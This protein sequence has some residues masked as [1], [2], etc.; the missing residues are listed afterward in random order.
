MFHNQ[1]KNREEAG[2]KLAERLLEW[3]E[4]NPLVLAIPRGGVAV[5]YEIAKALKAP[6]DII[7]PRKIGAP[8]NPELA[9]GAVTEDGTLVLNDDLVVAFRVSG[10]YVE[11]VRKR[12]IE[13]IKRRRKAYLGDTPL[14]SL[15]D[16]TVILVDDGIA[17]GATVR[18]AVESIRRQEPRVV[19][20]AAPVAP[21]E[22]VRA[23]EGEV[24]EVVCLVVFEP[25]FAIGQFY[26]DFSQV[27]D[28]EV[29]ELLKRSRTI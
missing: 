15:R 21:P 2:R 8:G 25:F 12:E 10:D 1:F 28:E 4:K 18:A 22:T 23:L 9:I 27:S 3:R 19:V 6:L 24:D 11:V 7:I 26:E 29:I 17:T 14:R 16:K 5:G 13:E 20:V